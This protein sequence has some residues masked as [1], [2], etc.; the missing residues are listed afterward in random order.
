MVVGTKWAGVSI[1]KTFHTRVYT[2][3]CEKQKI[4][5]VSRAFEGWN[6][7]LMREKKSVITLY[8]HVEQGS[9]SA[10]KT[11]QKIEMDELQQQKPTFRNRLSWAQTQKTGQLKKEMCLLL[12]GLVSVQFR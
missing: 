12:L 1:F 6:I 4:Y 7:L 9:I 11:H 3:L 2:E 8:N 5:P 10:C